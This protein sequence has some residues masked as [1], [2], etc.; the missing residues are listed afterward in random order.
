MRTGAEF[1]GKNERGRGKREKR[2]NEGGEWEK[3]HE[4]RKE[5]GREQKKKRK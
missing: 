2:E 5:E 1:C 4:K 3:K